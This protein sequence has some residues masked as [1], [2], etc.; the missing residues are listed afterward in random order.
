M[1]RLVRAALVVTGALT[2]S[3]VPTG[4]EEAPQAEHKPAAPPAL[5]PLS[6]VR[7]GMR[8]HGLTVMAGTKVERFEVEIVDVVRTWLVKQDL[9]LARCL[10]PAFEDHRIAQGMSGSPIYVDGRLIG[11]LAYT[12]GWSRHALAGITPIE[13]MIEEGTRPEEGRPTGA[14]PPTRVRTPR[15]APRALP[16]V[17][18]DAFPRGAAGGASDLRP[19]GTPLCVA[20]F[21]PEARASLAH[22]ARGLGFAVGAGGGGVAGPAQG[23]WV[24]T[25]AALEPGCSICVEMMRGDFGASAIGTCTHVDGN[26][27]YAF[28]HEFQAL[29]ETL[30]PMSLGYV[31]TIVSSDE[32]S[33]KLG[34]PLRPLGALVHDRASGIT[35][36]TDRQAP[37]V[38]FKINFK[39]VATGRSERFAFEITPHTILFQKL[40]IAA[41][42]DAFKRAEATLGPNTKRTT[43]TVDL[44]GMEP[45]TYSD[46]IAG[47][48]GGFQRTL[49]QLVDR[50]MNH[51]SQRAAFESVTLDVEIE[52]VDRRATIVSAVASVDEARPGQEITLD[53]RLESR[54]P[55]PVVLVTLPV[56]IPSDAVAGDYALAVMGGDFLPADVAAPKDLADLPRVFAAFSRSTEVVVVLPTGRVDLDVAG[57]M[58][59]SVPL[60]SLPRLVR[61]PGGTEAS[62]RPVTEKVRREVP[63]VVAGQRTVHLRIVR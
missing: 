35:G 24:D 39:N 51:E 61:A 63:F 19:I 6:E 18:P 17:P 14:A 7:P 1:H 43:M 41:V 42:Q 8:G 46:V 11:A 33:F 37:M 62:V 45:F 36:L 60:S 20:G 4:A 27:V 3:A 31:Y 28:G 53:V 50:V 40:L 54:E 38:P 26:R 57:R 56:R 21:S 49:I 25:N 15:E 44:E 30:L 29:G 55:G 47:F 32:I 5:M 10:G 34:A 48:D 12:W 23:G 59:R 9:I 13:T 16:D 52:H 2:L 22:E 58:L